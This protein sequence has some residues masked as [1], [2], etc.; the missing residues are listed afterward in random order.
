[1]ETDYYGYTAYR[2]FYTTADLA[3]RGAA[4]TFVFVD[5]HPNSINDGAFLTAMPVVGSWPGPAAWADLP[6][7]YHADAGCLSFADG[8]VEA[9]RWVDANTRLP[10]TQGL[11]LGTLAASPNDTRWL[12][13]K[14]SSPK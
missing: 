7:S 3:L 11:T 10:V 4:Q 12:V 2:N 6:A 9:H 8:H 5:E 1:M 14:A 13:S